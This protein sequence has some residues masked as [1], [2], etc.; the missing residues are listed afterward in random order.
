M[1]LKIK[2]KRVLI[3]GA[4]NGIGKTLAYQFAKEGCKLTLLARSKNKLNKIVKDLGGEKKGHFFFSVDL[5]PLGNAER[6]SKKILKTIG[7]HEIIIHCVGGGLGIKNLFS[8]YSDWQKVFRFNVG[9]GIEINNVFIKSLIKKKWGRIIHVSSIAAKNA[10]SE[11]DKIPY[12]ASKS[13]LNHYLVGLSKNVI[14]KNIVVSGVM[15]GPLLTKD[16]FWEKELKK[17]P[18]KVKKFIKKNYA[19]E[20]FARAEEICPFILLLASENASY[21]AGTII[22]ID[23]GKK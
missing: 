9:I 1:D 3:T 13:Y 7:T 11:F 8:S 12:A 15:P 10:D 5:L 23:G 4:S 16:K 20:R 18:Q 14:K 21:A 19:I 2:N 17:N 22:P 6:I